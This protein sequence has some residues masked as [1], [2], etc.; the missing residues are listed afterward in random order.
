MSRDVRLK[1]CPFCGGEAKFTDSDKGRYPHKVVCCK[2]HTKAG[3]SAYRNNLYNAKVWNT[4]HHN[5]SPDTSELLALTEKLKYILDMYAYS[6]PTDS[7]LGGPY[8][9]KVK[10]EAV[11]IIAKAKGD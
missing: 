7:E 2:C 11:E 10:R 9:D 6:V 3:G 1:P 4:R 5:L 8:C